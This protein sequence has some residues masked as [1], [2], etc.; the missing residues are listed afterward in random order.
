[1]S[2][3]LLITE[4]DQANLRTIIDSMLKGT[5]MSEHG[6]H[7]IAA[8]MEYMLNHADSILVDDVTFYNRIKS[9]EVTNES[10]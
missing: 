5:V 3:Y 4:D 1:M 6:R 10:I 2:T 9:D 8:Q 7:Y